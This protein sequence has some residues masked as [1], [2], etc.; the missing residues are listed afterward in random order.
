MNDDVD[1]GRKRQE[2]LAKDAER[3][4]KQRMS[5]SEEKKEQIRKSRGSISVV[6][7]RI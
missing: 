4:R 5:Y 6:E 2:K 7:D 1:K 3:K